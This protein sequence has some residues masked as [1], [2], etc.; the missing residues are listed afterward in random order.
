MPV[1]KI[2]VS[3]SSSLSSFIDNYKMTNGCK[4]RSQVIEE[5]LTLLR[6]KNLEKAYTEASAEIE[7]DW[8]VVAGDGLANETW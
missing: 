1:E 4:S 8:E 5:A 7:S 2:S 6:E 3:I